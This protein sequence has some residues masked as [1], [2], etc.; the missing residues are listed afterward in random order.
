MKK[1][2]REE[3]SISYYIIYKSNDKLNSNNKYLKVDMRRV[4]IKYTN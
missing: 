1:E 3:E 2:R 4:T